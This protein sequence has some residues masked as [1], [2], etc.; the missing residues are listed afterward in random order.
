MTAHHAILM[1][2][3]YAIAHTVVV[4]YSKTMLTAHIAA[5]N[6]IDNQLIYITLY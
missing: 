6:Y 4:K 5:A 1:Q 2:A 3:M